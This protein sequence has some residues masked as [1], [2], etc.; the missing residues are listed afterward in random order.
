[1]D[2]IILSVL[3]YVRAP[4]ILL[5]YDIACQWSKYFARRAASYPEGLQY[6][7]DADHFRVAIPKFHQYAHGLDCQARYSLNHLPDVART[8]G[9]GVETEWAYVNGIATST[10]EMSHAVRHETLNAHWLHWNWKKLIGLGKFSSY[11]L[12]SIF[13]IRS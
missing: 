9:E 1:M 12:N 8:C 10:R 4:E 6:T 2:F 11:T 5:T 13:L 7:V 3:K